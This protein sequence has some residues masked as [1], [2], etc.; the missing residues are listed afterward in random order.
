MTISSPFHFLIKSSSQKQTNNFSHI[1]DG[2]R[3]IYKN[4]PDCV[5][6]NHFCKQVWRLIRATLINRSY[7][8]ASWMSLARLQDS[9]AVTEATFIKS[10]LERSLAVPSLPLTEEWPWLNSLWWHWQLIN[11]LIPALCSFRVTCLWRNRTFFILQL[12][13]RAVLDL[14]AQEDTPYQ[15]DWGAPWDVWRRTGSDAA[16]APQHWSGSA[17]DSTSPPLHDLVS[18]QLSGSDGISVILQVFM[19]VSPRLWLIQNHWQFLLEL[20]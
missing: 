11:G 18:F 5:P 8:S 12:L 17:F 6:F 1:S 19:Q 16:K 7:A 10:K 2:E 14:P 9:T 15:L 4:L 20:S 13:E 3:T